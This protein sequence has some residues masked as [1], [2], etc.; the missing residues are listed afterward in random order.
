MYFS[1]P[2]FS[3]WRRIG[4]PKCHTQVNKDLD[5]CRGKLDKFMVIFGNESLVRRFRKA[6]LSAK[7]ECVLCRHTC[8]V[9]FLRM[10]STARAK[11]YQTPSDPASMSKCLIAPLVSARAAKREYA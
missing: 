2:Q 5:T 7:R 11:T 3:M 4:R 10:G 1:Y 8:D 9:S 6:H